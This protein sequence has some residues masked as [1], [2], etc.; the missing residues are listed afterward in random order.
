MARQARCNRVHSAVT[1]QVNVIEAAIV[2]VHAVFPKFGSGQLP[3]LGLS[4]RGNLAQCLLEHLGRLAAGNQMPVIDDDRRHRMNP[5]A[6][7]KR[8]ALAHFIGVLGCC[9]NFARAH[10]VKARL[11]SHPNQHLMRSGALA[12]GNRP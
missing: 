2:S 12:V 5:L 4:R 3:F 10:R 9:Q 1:H 6:E 8:L 11:A 7:I